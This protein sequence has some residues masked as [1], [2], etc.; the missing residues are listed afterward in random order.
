MLRISLLFIGL[1]LSILQSYNAVLS[2]QT[3]FLAFLFGIL[4]LG[5][6]HGAADL[7]VA[8]QN[9]TLQK[10]YFSTV[11][12]L[13]NYVG[14]LLLFATIFWFFPLIA[15]I[16]FIFLAAYH[17]GETDLHRFRTDT[18]TGKFLVITYG[19]VI[20]SI[21]LLP[22]YEEVKQIFLLF[23]SGA[24]NIDFI[25]GID[26]QRQNII[27]ACFSLFFISIVNYYRKH[28]EISLKDFSQVLLQLLV[29][30]FIVYRLPMLLG[31]T[32][33]FVFWHS[34]LSL[35][36]IVKY[37][38]RNRQNSYSIILKQVLFYSSLAILGIA[39]FGF[40][41]TMLISSSVITG[42]LFLGLAVLTAPHMEVMHE[43]YRQLRNA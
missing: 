20:L 1:T 29:I 14:R 5:I 32:F 21:I 27:F 10:Q 35:N 38:K 9:E 36:N 33:Y 11:Y 28:K 30:L 18:Y 4:L 2:V 37:L 39:L 19:L 6:P 25:N 22:H 26:A 12:F 41:G 8:N 16:L 23:P 43:M 34:I 15:N 7:L 24:A 13:L 40:M 17:F 31:F 3:Q 42:Y